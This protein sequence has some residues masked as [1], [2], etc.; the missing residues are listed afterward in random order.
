[1]E[2]V[3]NKSLRGHYKLSISW[4]GYKYLVLKKNREEGAVSPY[5]NI[6]KWPR[7]DLDYSR[8]TAK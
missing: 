4:R 2:S 8:G 7:S 1:M 6:S 3:S 5:H